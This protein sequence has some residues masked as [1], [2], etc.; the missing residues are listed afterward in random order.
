[1][2]VHEVRLCQAHT[3]GCLWDMLGAMGA[4]LRVMGA[5]LGATGT[6][7]E[8]FTVDYPKTARMTRGNGVMC[9]SG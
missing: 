1:M 8:L 7:S 6:R 5:S 9:L 3:Q 2:P 4:V